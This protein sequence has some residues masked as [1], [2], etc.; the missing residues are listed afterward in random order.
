[1][2]NILAVALFAAGIGITVLGWYLPSNGIR[3]FGLRIVVAACG[4]ALL[5]LDAFL[6]KTIVTGG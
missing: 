1:M 2:I 3:N 4:G 6:I 5:G